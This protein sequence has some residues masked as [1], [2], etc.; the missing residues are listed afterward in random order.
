MHPGS[1]P[2]RRARAR[3]GLLLT[4]GESQLVIVDVQE[5]L[6]PAM[7][8][9]AF[10]RTMATLR[11][12]AIAAAATGVPSTITEHVPDRIGPTTRVVRD[13]F[14]EATVISKVHFS[15]ANERTFLERL[16]AF[17][18]PQLLVCGMETH[19]CVLQTA[20]GLAE[21]GAAVR[22]VTDACCARDDHDQAI[23]LGRAEAAGLGLVTG[24]M[25]AFEWLRRADHPARHA[26]IEAVK[27]K[28]AGVTPGA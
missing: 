16:A 25:V 11:L 6:A 24:E 8:A 17:D 19:V 14:R 12:L 20:L 7:P 18:R 5:R 28:A 22:L 3:Q 1:D 2:S 9:A 10:A 15:A 27:A 13:L 26:V 23:A 4:P 21:R